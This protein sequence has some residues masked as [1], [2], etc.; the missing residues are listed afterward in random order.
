V[1]SVRRLARASIVTAVVLASGAAVSQDR[2]LIGGRPVYNQLPDRDWVFFN[3][4]DSFQSNAWMK[5]ED[6][7]AVVLIVSCTKSRGTVFL[8]Y[9]ENLK[10][11]PVRITMLL[12]SGGRTVLSE[13]A[14]GDALGFMTRWVEKPDFLKAMRGLSGRTTLTMELQ[15]GTNRREMT[16][17]FRNDA[18]F[19][20]A[21]QRCTSL[22]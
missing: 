1:N 13:E 12:R 19:R 6:G 8:R 22:M 17:R 21:L 2:Q 5:A 11:D 4:A 3:E 15:G 20:R 10:Q 16:L 9:V 18:G 7:T 14:E